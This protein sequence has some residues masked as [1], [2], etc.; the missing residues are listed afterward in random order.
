MPDRINLKSGN[1]V[2]LWHERLIDQEIGTFDIEA[3]QETIRDSR[4]N[5]PLASAML[6]FCLKVILFRKAEAYKK[7]D[8]RDAVMIAAAGDFLEVVSRAVDTRTQEETVHVIRQS[9]HFGSQI[10][11]LT[12]VLWSF[13]LPG[14]EKPGYFD[15]TIITAICNADS[16]NREKLMATFP[17]LVMAVEFVQKE[18]AI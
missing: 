9:A 10:L 8:G 3:I 7:S 16:S 14:G 13:D 11:D 18:I 12:H 4:A 6:E 5:K 17:Y 15:R 2:W 1:E